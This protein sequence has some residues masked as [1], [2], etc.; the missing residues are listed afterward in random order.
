MWS[1]LFLKGSI[2]F[3]LKLN[4]VIKVV[5][6]LPASAAD[7]RDIPGSGRSLEEGMVTHSSALAWRI[8]WTEE[9][10]RVRPIGLQSQTR[11]ER[12]STLQWLKNAQLTIGES[13][14]KKQRLRSARFEDVFSSLLVALSHYLTTSD[15]RGEEQK[16]WDVDFFFFKEIAKGRDGAFIVQRKQI[17]R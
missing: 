3:F 12:L 13:L 9:P 5:K 14:G 1:N 17:G 2:N 15:W 10:G 7:L 8:P 16:F 6:N 4:I 11:L